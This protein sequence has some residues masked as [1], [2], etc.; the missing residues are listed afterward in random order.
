MEL[1]LFERILPILAA[2]AFIPF[3]VNAQT[4]GEVPKI[5]MIYMG[6]NDCPPCVYWRG[7]EL[8]KLEQTEAFKSIT[9]SYVIKT[10]KSS[11]P[12]SYFLPDEVK[13]Y[14]EKLDAAGAGH[15]GSAQVAIIVNGE[16]YDY[17]FGTRSAEDVEKMILAI[18][19]KEKYPFRRCVKMA[20]WGKC[21]VYG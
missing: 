18:T 5:H 16:V 11:V 19:K 8:P 2:V 10:I 1:R 9:F 3:S 20:G 6:G 12:S 7:N 4:S 15:G 17:Y 14:K 21:A 13:P